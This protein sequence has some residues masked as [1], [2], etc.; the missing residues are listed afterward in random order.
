MTCREF[1]EWIVD[2]VDGALPQEGHLHCEQH[3]ECC[4]A[5]GEYLR[6]YRQT[7]A[8]GRAAFCE[9]GC[10]AA[11]LDALVKAVLDVRRRG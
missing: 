8:L 9:P 2:Y 1:T 11:A 7:I 3:L 10:S 5:C 6:Q 4:C